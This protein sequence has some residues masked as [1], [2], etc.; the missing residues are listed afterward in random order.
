MD[1]HVFKAKGSISLRIAGIL[2]LIFGILG[3]I[4]LIIAGGDSTDDVP[5][6]LILGFAILFYSFFIY[7]F[8]RNFVSINLN[9]TKLLYYKEKE[10][11]EKTQNV[12][13]EVH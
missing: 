5:I 2:F 3:G 10:D 13:E 4:P 12:K 7:A 9:L 6:E 8:V 11:S 1:I